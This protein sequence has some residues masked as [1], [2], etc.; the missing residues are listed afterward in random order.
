MKDRSCGSGF[1]CS[2]WFGPL[3][4][5]VSHAGAAGGCC[6]MDFWKAEPGHGFLEYP[7]RGIG[8]AKLIFRFE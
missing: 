4:H 5:G 3:I 6:L 2:T 1:L 7:A 8:G